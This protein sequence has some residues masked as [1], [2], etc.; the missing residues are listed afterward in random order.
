MPDAT[1]QP[2]GKIAAGAQEK[3]QKDASLIED[4]GR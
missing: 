4:F 3:P 1:N 2:D